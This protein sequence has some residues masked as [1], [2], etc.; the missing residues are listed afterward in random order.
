MFWIVR[1]YAIPNPFEALGE[2]LVVTIRE[3]PILLSP[4]LLNWMADPIIAA[5]T[6]GIVGLYYISGSAPALGSILYMVFYA[7]H[8]GLLYLI[9][10][11][12][13]IIW[14]M[15]LVGV[16]DIGIHIGVIALRGVLD[17]RY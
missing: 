3:V 5:F 12:Y 4:E 2:G 9:L 16:I 6:F 15:V 7:L 8:I 11:L 14:L 13:P 1:Q 17:W 10:S